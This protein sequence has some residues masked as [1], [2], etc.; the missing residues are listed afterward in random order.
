MMEYHKGQIY[1][2][3]PVEAKE[4]TAKGYVFVW[5]GKEPHDREHPKIRTYEF[6]GRHTAKTKTMK[7]D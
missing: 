1:E 4:L 6:L 3:S 2:M 7:E 5:K